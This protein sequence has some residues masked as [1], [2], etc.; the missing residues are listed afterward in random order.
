[1]GVTA[2]IVLACTPTSAGRDWLSLDP[3]FER[4]QI[5][6]GISLQIGDTSFTADEDVAT[7]D[8]DFE[9][10]PIQTEDVAGYGTGALRQR[11]LPI[12][13]SQLK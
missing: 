5:L 11:G 13:R 1:M 6:A 3:V 7:A 12:T 2:V 8:A 4:W 10:C 9:R